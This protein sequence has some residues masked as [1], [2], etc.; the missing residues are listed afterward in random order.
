MSLSIRN[1]Q[2]EHFVLHILSHPIRLI[3]VPLVVNLN[4]VA[5]AGQLDFESG[6]LSIKD[7]L[8][9]DKQSGNLY[10]HAA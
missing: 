1:R 5:G 9:V 8:Q 10:T 4:R 2:V 7:Y 3:P 6:E